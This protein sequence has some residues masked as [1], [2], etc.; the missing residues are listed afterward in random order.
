[1]YS[2]HIE[3]GRLTSSFVSMLKRQQPASSQH[4]FSQDVLVSGEVI[5][6]KSNSLSETSLYCWHLGI[7]QATVSAISRCWDGVQ[8]SPVSASRV[9]RKRTGFQQVPNNRTSGWRAGVSLLSKNIPSGWQTGVRLFSSASSVVDGRAFNGCPS[10]Q[11]HLTDES[12]NKNCLRKKTYK[13]NFVSPGHS[14]Y[15]ALYLFYHSKI[16]I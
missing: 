8:H 1:M 15:G 4:L 7:Q 2:T 11:Q 3:R 6:E 12:V 16:D 13:I 9:W 14:S 5:A 10:S